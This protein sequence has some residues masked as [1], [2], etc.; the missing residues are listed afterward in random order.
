MVKK[1]PAGRTLV[2][3]GRSRRGETPKDAVLSIRAHKNRNDSA[4]YPNLGRMILH[5]LDKG[6]Y[7]SQ[8]ARNRGSTLG[9]VPA[10]LRRQACLQREQLERNLALT[11]FFAQWPTHF[12]IGDTG[13][14]AAVACPRDFTK[15]HKG[16]ANYS[17]IF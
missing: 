12:S 5:P 16:K 13:K 17:V 7:Y 4:R 2:S 3:R 6:S 14:P 11:Y 10:E 8:K 1:G 9:K 15:I